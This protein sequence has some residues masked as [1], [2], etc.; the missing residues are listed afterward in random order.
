MALPEA[1]TLLLSEL[2]TSFGEDLFACLRYT[3]SR[4]G[5]GAPE[6]AHTIEEWFLHRFAEFD[7][8]R[9]RGLIGVYRSA[10]DLKQYEALQARSPSNNARKP[11]NREE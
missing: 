1:T 3:E 10:D 8:L 4:L 7:F 2:R 11:N 6:G 5:E 9:D